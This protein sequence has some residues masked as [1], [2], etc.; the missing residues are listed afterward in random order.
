MKSNINATPN[1]PL[2]DKNEPWVIPQTVKPFLKPRTPAVS[3][4]LEE[5]LAHLNRMYQDPEYRQMVLDRN[6]PARHSKTH[7]LKNA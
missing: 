2:S 7:H 5:T 1:L 4:M 6:K 3:A